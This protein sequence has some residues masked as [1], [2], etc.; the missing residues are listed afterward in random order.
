MKVKSGGIPCFLPDAFLSLLGAFQ[1][2]QRAESLDKQ[3]LYPESLGTQIASPCFLASAM[4]CIQL[5]WQQRRLMEK[6]HQP[7][8]F[9]L[10]AYVLTGSS[11][12][13][14]QKVNAQPTGHANI[15]AK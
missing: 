7:A 2:V 15:G 10:D 8:E 11:T 12:V 4:R 5:M 6:G 14:C 3:S 1:L 13:Y 9:R